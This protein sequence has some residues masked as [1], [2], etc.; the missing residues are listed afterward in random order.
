MRMPSRIEIRD[1]TIAWPSIASRNAPIVASTGEPNSFRA[2]SHRSGTASVPRIAT[3]MRQ[4][5]GLSAPNRSMP[6]PMTSLPS[7]GCTT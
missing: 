6:R 5:K 1:V 4:P 2:T 7:G 3:P